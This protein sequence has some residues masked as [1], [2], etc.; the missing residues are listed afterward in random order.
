MVRDLDAYPLSPKQ[1]RTLKHAGFTQ[2]VDVVELS[3]SQL[4]EGRYLFY[5]STQ[6]SLSFKLLTFSN[7]LE[8]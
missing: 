8:A 5:Y 3:P 4:S 2:N 1:L 6:R 7:W